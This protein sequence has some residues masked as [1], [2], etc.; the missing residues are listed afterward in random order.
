MNRIKYCAIMAAGFVALA[1]S[2]AFASSVC[3]VITGGNA[4]GGGGVSGTYI[5]DGGVTDGGCTD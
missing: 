2:P 1:A 5:T 4:G 3:P